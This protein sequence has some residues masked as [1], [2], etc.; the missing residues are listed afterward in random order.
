MPSLI[1]ELKAAAVAAFESLNYPTALV[2]VKV[3]D[4]PDLSHFQ[5]NSAFLLAKELKK[6]P[7]EIAT[8]VAAKL[9]E[10]GLFESVSVDGPGFINLKVTPALLTFRMETLQSDPRLGVETVAAPKAVTLDYCGPNIAKPMHVGHIR[11]TIIGDCL[12]RLFTFLG[13]DVTSDIHFGDWGTQMGMLI[14]QFRQDYPSSEVF[15]KT[16]A[17]GEE[18]DLP[19]DLEG[20]EAL[21]RKA[22]ARSKSDEAALNEMRQATVELQNGNPLY[23]AI[24]RRFRSLSIADVRDNLDKLGVEFDLWN[25]ESDYNDIAKQLTSEWKAKGIAHESEGALIIPMEEFNLP[26]ILLHKSDGAILY[27]TTDLAALYDRAVNL[28]QDEAVYVVDQRQSL[29]FK[30]VFNAADKL[31]IMK[32][33][34]GRHVGF[35]T[36]NGKD[37]KPFKTRD[38]GVVKLKDLIVD[39]ITGAGERIEEIAHVDELSADEKKSIA[40]MVGIAALKFADLINNRESDYAFD[41]DKFLKFEG[42]TGPYLLY[43]AVRIKSILRKTAEKG[44]KAGKFAAPSDATEASL[45][46]KLTVLPETLEKA[47]A[48]CMP[49]YLCEYT[50]ELASL[51][52]QF[53]TGH[54]ILAQE[55]KIV[56]ASWL[57]LCEL[58]LRF[59]EQL[60]SIIG[61]EIPER[62]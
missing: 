44:L 19:I 18:A 40:K 14:W 30:Q 62:M 52:N 39:A 42:K 51:F 57:A 16:Y 56:Q 32:G 48:D 34:S 1:Q 23:M 17:P 47:A 41:L 45:M 6:N 2:E 11:S 60:S 53:Y 33:M 58:T 55:D 15:N 8:A 35:G 27:H 24:W 5:C 54:N 36:V 7:R 20:L 49:S 61:I 31:G 38:G 25:G 29:H 46:L 10:S 12:K 26:P 43:T 4:R 50:H 22:S 37:G 13:H 59:M 21:Y 9:T 28:K 3:S